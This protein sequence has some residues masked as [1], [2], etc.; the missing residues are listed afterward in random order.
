[1]DKAIVF[2]DD[3]EIILDSLKEQVTRHLGNEYLY[4]TASNA[5][6][7]FEIIEELYAEH[8]PV[9]VVVSDWYMPGMKGD[10]LLIKLKNKYPDMQCIMLTGQA[11]PQAIQRAKTEAGV[12]AVIS[13]PWEESELISAIHS[14]L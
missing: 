13:K 6:E 9:I 11:T 2:V 1:M 4:E 7:S 3:E 8:I 12:G 14:M 10:E 5:E